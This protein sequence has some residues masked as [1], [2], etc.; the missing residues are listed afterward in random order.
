ML[1]LLGLRPC[2]LSPVHRCPDFCT[3]R[4]Q[5]RRS[6]TNRMSLSNVVWVVFPPIAVRNQLLMRP[7]VRGQLL[8]ARSGLPEAGCGHRRKPT[9]DRSDDLNDRFT[10]KRIRSRAPH[11]PSSPPPA[12]RFGEAPPRRSTT[13]RPRPPRAFPL[14]LTPRQAICTWRTSLGTN[15]AKE[16]GGRRDDSTTGDIQRAPRRPRYS[17]WRGFCVS[18]MD[19]T[20]AT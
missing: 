2:A 15:P 4:D 3:T 17:G 11:K 16:A 9:G 19:S 10:R 20:A 1:Y 7:R 18:T 13:P 12:G 6:C 8:A 14:D 5:Q